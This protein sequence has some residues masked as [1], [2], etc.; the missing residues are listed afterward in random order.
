MQAKLS[1]IMQ[2]W[3]SNFGCIFTFIPHLGSLSRICG[4]NVGNGGQIESKKNSKYASREGIIFFPIRF[5]ELNKFIFSKKVFRIKCKNDTEGKDRYLF[6][7]KV[8]AV[9]VQFL[10]FLLYNSI[11][12]QN[13]T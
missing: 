6:F 12:K 10:I 11:Y 1:H 8:S 9:F 5:R 4:M 7:I 2:D 3:V 13:K